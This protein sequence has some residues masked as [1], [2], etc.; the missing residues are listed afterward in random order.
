MIDQRDVAALLADPARAVDVPV[1]DVRALL[2]TV[3][4]QAARLDVVKSILAARLASLP[5]GP[6]A[7]PNGVPR[8]VT[9]AEAAATFG[10]P[11]ADV[12]YLTRR[13]IIPAIGKGKNKRLLPADLER[14]LAHCARERLAV[15]GIPDVSCHRD[16]RRSAAGPQGARDDATDLR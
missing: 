2:D 5:H 1:G 10:I 14:H 15:R 8:Y 11:L 9:Q 3:S 16:R 12:R 6:S 4:A 13:G 7:A